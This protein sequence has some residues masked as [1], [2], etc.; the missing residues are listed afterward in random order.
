MKLGI[1]FFF[2]KC[3]I[4]IA[5]QL[6]S[7]KEI[8]LQVKVGKREGTVVDGFVV[9]SGSQLGKKKYVIYNTS[10]K[11]TLF[12]NSQEYCY[13]KVKYACVNNVL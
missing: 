8:N 12:C 6:Q 11:K 1:I 7:K 3:L 9:S 5:A 2:F 4:K 10:E 13:Q